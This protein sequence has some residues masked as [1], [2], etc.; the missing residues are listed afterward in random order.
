M[1]P[2]PLQAWIVV[3]P[4]CE[5]SVRTRSGKMFPAR[6]PLGEVLVLEEKPVCY[7]D[8]MS[9]W[10]RQDCKEGSVDGSED[11]R[12]VRVATP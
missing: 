10:C 1:A 3:E 7:F 5:L 9:V 11:Q 4:G 2:G 8:G 12:T 6:W